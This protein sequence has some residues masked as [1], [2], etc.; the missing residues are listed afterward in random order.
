M[1][2]KECAYLFDVANLK[3]APKHEEVAL[4]LGLRP[5]LEVH[6]S[7]VRLAR[8][9]GVK[10][11]AVGDA[12]RKVLNL[13]VVRLQ[14]LVQPRKQLQSTDAAPLQPTEAHSR[15]LRAG[16]TIEFH[17]IAAVAVPAPSKYIRKIAQLMVRAQMA[18]LVALVSKWR[19]GDWVA[20]RHYSQ[21]FV[22]WRCCEGRVWHC[23]W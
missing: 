2:G 15:R 10:Y 12:I 18:L 7:Q 6:V 17:P 13:G 11:L 14:E 22:A 16:D 3:C 5:R 23:C 20:E 4:E 21:P 9:E 19:V 8:E 1:T